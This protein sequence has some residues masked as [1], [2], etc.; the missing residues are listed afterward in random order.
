MFGPFGEPQ[1]NL[2]GVRDANVRRY[3][4][5][6]WISLI[7]SLICLCL[8]SISYFYRFGYFASRGNLY[9]QQTCC[10]LSKD[11]SPFNDDGWI[12]EEHPYLLG[13]RWT[14]SIKLRPVG[15]TTPPHVLVPLWIPTLLSA[16]A[17]YLC[18]RISKPKPI[19][20]CRRCSYNLT[21]N[22]TGVCPE[23]GTAK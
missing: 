18:H 15:A 4:K 13:F 10:I 12:V 2:P 21:G 6:A 5:L 3:R 14:P 17:A 20:H 8:L 22:L 16:F 7:S 19:G 23:C 9:C 1:R 11:S